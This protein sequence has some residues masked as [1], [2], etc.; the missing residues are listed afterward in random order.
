MPVDRTVV[1]RYFGGR[2]FMPGHR[3]VGESAARPHERY[4]MKILA[5]LAVLVALVLPTSASA[6]TVVDVTLEQSAFSGAFR[7]CLS[8]TPTAGESGS[9]SIVIRE[10]SGKRY[11]AIGGIEAY[12]APWYWRAWC[13]PLSDYEA[14][15]GFGWSYQ[16]K[17]DRNVVASG[18]F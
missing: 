14:A 8:V 16:V 3:P 18:V 15:G 4:R 10:P 1:A 9:Y 6:A 13:V 5:L 7:Y 2:R 11:K 17:L 12:P